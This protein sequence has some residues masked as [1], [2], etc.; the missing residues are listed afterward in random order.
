MNNQSQQARKRERGQS[1]AEFVMVVPFLLLLFFLMVDFGWI[2]KNYLVVTNT[3]R[4]V[5]RCAVV[6]KCSVDGT[7]VGP[8][9]LAKSRISAGLFSNVD[10]E[11][12]DEWYFEIFY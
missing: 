9:E 12:E 5:A 10:V 2:F 1:T 6:S 4:E 8:E 7:E 11:D 3:G